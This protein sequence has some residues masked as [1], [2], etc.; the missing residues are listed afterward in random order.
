MKK[1]I[2]TIAVLAVISALAVTGY[3]YYQD[4]TL[5]R[6]TLDSE[7]NYVDRHYENIAS[8]RAR[9]Y[10]RDG[11]SFALDIG[12]FTDKAAAAREITAMIKRNNPAQINYGKYVYYVE[13][14]KLFFYQSGNQIVSI[15]SSAP[16]EVIDTFIFWLIKRIEPI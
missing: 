14:P 6:L 10:V 13:E 4:A 12:E 5:Y 7:R 8:E 1:A 11:D 15:T 3:Y 9:L 16:K 2:I